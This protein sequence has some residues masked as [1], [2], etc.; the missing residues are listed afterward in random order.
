[1]TGLALDAYLVAVRL[2]MPVALRV[3]SL[4]GWFSAIAPRRIATDEARARRAIARAQRVASRLHLPDTCL[5]RAA[6]R[7]AGLRAAGLDA[8]FVMGIRRDDPDV[9]HAWVELAGVPVG[10]ARDERLV[11]T[12]AYP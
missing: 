9:G 7:F 11:P 5:Y 8:R 12:F 3:T 1:M 4:P 2:A 6:A 10:E